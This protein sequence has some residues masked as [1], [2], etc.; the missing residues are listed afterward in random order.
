MP[1]FLLVRFS[2]IGD[3][4]LTSPVIRCLKQQ[5]HDAEVHYLTK[6]NFKSVIEYNPFIDKKIY[7]EGELNDLVAQLKNERY[8]YLIDL[9]HNLRTLRLRRSLGVPT[10]SFNKLNIEKW[11]MVNLKINKLPAVHIVER[12]METVK[13]F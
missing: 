11:L 1:K 9:H 8:D 6:K 4:V 13:E 10:F 12:Y 2:S 7:L 5:V 3:I